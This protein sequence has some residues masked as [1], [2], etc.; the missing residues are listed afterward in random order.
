MKVPVLLSVMILGAL[1][2]CLAPRL[3]ADFEA[4]LKRWEGRPCAEFIQYKGAPQQSKPRPGGGM[5]HV[6]E[7]RNTQSGPQQT[8]RFARA[9]GT[10][11]PAIAMPKGATGYCRLILETDPAGIILT[12]RWEGNDCW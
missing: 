8:A 3:K 11:G 5:I 10:L 7:T 9:D 6:F 1:T 12:T 4:D 2:A